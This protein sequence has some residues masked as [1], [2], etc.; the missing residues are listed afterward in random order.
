[1]G[2]SADLHLERFRRRMEEAERQRN[3]PI[4]PRS[5][6][7][8]LTADQLDHLASGICNHRTDDERALCSCPCH[9]RPSVALPVSLAKGPRYRLIDMKETP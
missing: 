7:P 1:M 4:L 5:S 6:R 3:A 9:R 2:W 8:H